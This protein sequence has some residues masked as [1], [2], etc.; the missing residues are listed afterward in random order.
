MQ[1][2]GEEF[3]DAMGMLEVQPPNTA[4]Q[5]GKGRA[6]ESSPAPAPAQDDGM[7][8]DEDGSQQR[9]EEQQNAAI[10]EDNDSDPAE[11][12]GAEHNSPC[13]PIIMRTGAASGTCYKVSN[14][15]AW[16]GHIIMRTLPF[17]VGQ[18]TAPRHHSGPLCRPGD[19]R[20][21]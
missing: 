16:V 4:S 3:D 1:E 14:A 18:F 13:S 20:E 17:A 21:T 5:K 19:C 11:A 2:P 9:D 10:N 7:N 6:V 12:N 8:L 15:F